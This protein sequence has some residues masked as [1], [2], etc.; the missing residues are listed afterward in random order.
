MKKVH[1]IPALK[2]QVFQLKP[3]THAAD[4]SWLLGVTNSGPTDSTT[5]M[6]GLLFATHIWENLLCGLSNQNSDSNDYKQNVLF[7]T[8]PPRLQSMLLQRQNHTSL[9]VQAV[10]GW[11]YSHGSLGP[12]RL[13][14]LHRAAGGAAGSWPQG[15]QQQSA[16][17]CLYSGALRSSGVSDESRT[18]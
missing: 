18:W 6:N 17:K 9:V 1:M 16:S 10:L 8:W 4:T 7:P 12:G 14:G 11:G 15:E 2:L 13:R 3:Q 5:T